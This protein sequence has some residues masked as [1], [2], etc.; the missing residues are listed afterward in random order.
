MTFFLRHNVY[1]I[2]DGSAKRH[3][4][5]YV[6][7]WSAKFQQQYMHV[8]CPQILP[9]H[10]LA[11]LQTNH[12][13]KTVFSFL[14]PLTTLH[15]SHLLQKWQ[16]QSRCHLGCGPKKP[17]LRRGQHPSRGNCNLFFF[18]GGHLTIV[19]GMSSA[20]VDKQITMLFGM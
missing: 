11:S 1:F 13:H 14:H 18:G 19:C 10:S 5:I 16:N 20:D 17:L 6:Q 2:F 4:V 15:C 7:E 12:N 8:V 9:H 3:G